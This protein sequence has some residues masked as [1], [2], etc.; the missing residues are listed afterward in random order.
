MESSNGSLDDNDTCQYDPSMKKRTPSPRVLGAAS[1]VY[2]REPVS[3]DSEE[4]ITLNRRSIHFYKGLT[5]PILTPQQFANYIGQCKRDDFEA[6]LVCRVEDGIIVGAINLSQ[7]VRG[8]FKSAYLGYQVGAPFAG[9]GYM[10]EGLRLVLRHAFEAMKLHRL[11]ANIQPS[12]MAS[13]ALVKRAGFT[14]EGYSRRYLKINGRLRHH[15]RWA[16]IAEDWR[17]TNTRA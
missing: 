4:F 3:A 2:L 14:K 8:I 7:I 5:S 13:I 16:L 9:H 6:T 15:E 10:T 17:L 12:N 1:I 11:E